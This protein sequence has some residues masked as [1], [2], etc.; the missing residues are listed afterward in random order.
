VIRSK[1]S[2]AGHKEKYINEGGMAMPGRVG[3]RLL[4]NPVQ[5]AGGGLL[6]VE[7]GP[8]LGVKVDF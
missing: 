6:Q 4:C 5:M 8:H 1:K 2:V 3:Q 7:L